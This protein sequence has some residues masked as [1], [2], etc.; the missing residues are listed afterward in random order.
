MQS[1]VIMFLAFLFPEEDG[2]LSRF[3]IGHMQLLLNLS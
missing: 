3:G 2:K 1:K